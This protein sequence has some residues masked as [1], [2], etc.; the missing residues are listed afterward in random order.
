M[1]KFTRDL[2]EKLGLRIGKQKGNELKG[3]TP[4]QVLKTG[5]LDQEW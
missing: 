5:W 3:S 2:A 1:R 4:Y